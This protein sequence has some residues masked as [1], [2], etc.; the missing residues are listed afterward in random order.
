LQWFYE[1]VV[2]LRDL[3]AEDGSIYTHRDFPANAVI[4]Y[5]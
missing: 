1:T 3:L 4:A 5:E 2:L